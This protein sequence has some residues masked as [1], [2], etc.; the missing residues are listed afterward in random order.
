MKYFT[1]KYLSATEFKGSRIKATCD[2]FNI[3]IPYNDNLENEFI[4]FQAVKALVKK[5][6]L[7]WDIS[8][9]IH[10]SNDYGYVFC[11]PNSIIE[12]DKKGKATRSGGV[13]NYSGND[14]LVS[15]TVKTYLKKYWKIRLNGGTKDNANKGN[16]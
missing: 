15:L 8:K 7:D 13:V 4:H 11:F 5:Y 1:T 14:K 2:K 16:N 3:T 6:N 10:G 12:D 9:M